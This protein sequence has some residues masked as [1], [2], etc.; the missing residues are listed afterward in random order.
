MA[1]CEASTRIIDN[2]AEVRP[3][4]LF[5]VPRIFNKHLHGGAG[6]DRGQAQ[7]RAGD[8]EGR[9]SKVTAKERAGE[10]L[11]LHELALLELVDKL[12]FA[13]VRARFGG[14]LKYAFCGGA[15]LSREVAEFID[16]ARASW[17]TRATA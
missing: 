5:S 1:I 15:A 12:V 17:S 14:R 16:C 8:G 13:K 9:R 11:K 3:T 2:L 7:G 10:R 6:A 4:L